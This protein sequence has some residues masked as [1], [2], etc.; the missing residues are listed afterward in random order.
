MLLIIF[1][2]GLLIGSF[3]N[4]FLWRYQNKV[5]F[6][7]RSICPNCK[8]TIKWY[9][10]IPLLSYLILGGKCR[11]CH[12]RISIQYPIVEVV[13][14]LVFL[15][16]GVAW[17]IIYLPHDS[18]FNL[19]SNFDSSYQ[20]TIILFVMLAISAVLILISVYDIQTK[21]IP[22]SFN[23]TYGI[24]AVIYI[25]TL[26]VQGG[27]SER[28]LIFH[29]ITGVLL[30]LSFW[31]LVYFSKETWMGGGD[32]KFVLAMGFLLGPLFSLWGILI[33]SLVGSVYGLSMIYFSKESKG[34]RKMSLKSQ[35]P[36][37]PFLALGSWLILLFGSQI[38]DYYVRITL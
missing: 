11:N 24:L 13:T 2:F 5:S 38:L 9:D 35:V 22:D 14:G 7:G 1:I 20:A 33:A 37:G 28:Q 6:S 16:T 30:F 31:A 32:A 29:I 12:K 18:F 4:S 19:I 17:Q 27:I 34:S 8:K 36:F 10:N 21:E 23:V 25:G 3:I 26:F 15:I